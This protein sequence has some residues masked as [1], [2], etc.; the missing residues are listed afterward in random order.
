MKEGSYS[1]KAHPYLI[2]PLCLA[3]MSRDCHGYNKPMWVM[4]RVRVA[5]FNVKQTHT[6]RKGLMAFHICAWSKPEWG[7]NISIECCLWVNGVLSSSSVL[8]LSACFFNGFSFLSSFLLQNNHHT[9]KYIYLSTFSPSFPKLL[10]SDALYNPGPHLGHLP[11]LQ[12][13]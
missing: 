13:S 11:R 7:T 6:P 3:S 4:G 1:L 12:R 5:F 2:A 9:S 10:S 8:P